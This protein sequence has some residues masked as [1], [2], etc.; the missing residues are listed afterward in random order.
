MNFFNKYVLSG[1]LTA[2]MLT[3]MSCRHDEISMSDDPIDSYT[4]PRV[5]LTISPIDIGA[6][7]DE[8]IIEKIRTLRIIM[9]SEQPDETGTTASYV[10]L[11]R[12][13]D[14][15]NS[16]E[17]TGP[18]EYARYFRYV[19][20]RPTLAGVKKF[21]LIANEASVTPISFQTE[22]QLPQGVSDGMNL[23]DFLNLYTPNE[24]PGFENIPGMSNGEGEPS[25]EEFETLLNSIYYAPEFEVTSVTEDD[26]DST[27]GVT[28]GQ[29]IFLPYS[30]FYTFEVSDPA[31]ENPDA[32]PVNVLN[33]NI[34]LVPAA[35]KFIF[36]FRNYRP[37]ELTIESF[38]L[39]GMADEMFLFAQV[40][41]GD[42]VKQL[43]K[44]SLWWVNWLAA[45]SQLS[46]PENSMSHPDGTENEV[47]NQTYGW[48]SDFNV[49][50]TAFN[51]DRDA[52]INM[53]ERKGVY[54]FIT[55]GT[56]NVDSRDMSQP[57]NSASPGEAQTGYF[58]MPESRNLVT[59]AIYDNEGNDTGETREVERY[60]LTMTMHDASYGSQTVTKD[61][62]IGNLGSMFRNNNTLITVTLRDANDVGAY[63]MPVPWAEKHSYG[64]V[65][66]EETP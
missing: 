59:T 57:V 66:E 37:D 22:D 54:E 51:P 35:N 34:Y 11:N 13:I 45:V 1:L 29:Q 15:E 64:N 33:E 25:G 16:P 58:Y 26:D 30:S 31:V 39:S 20:T 9:I 38:R 50:T 23:S 12:Y 18:G 3:M 8:D 48:I 17:F 46:Y 47:F 62:P 5:I 43:N 44:V 56:W 55:E 41:Q 61:T 10:E 42:Q 63:A 24:I 7:V 52:T 21:Y 53:E 2:G 49:P 32:P 19:F 65:I 28:P 60:Y 4:G 36:K 14:F 6:G 27:A 40:N